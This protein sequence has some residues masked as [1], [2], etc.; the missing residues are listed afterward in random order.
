M[1]HNQVLEKHF[2]IEVTWLQKFLF[3]NPTAQDEIT[4]TKLAFHDPGY[5]IKSKVPEPPPPDGRY[6]SKV[7]SLYFTLQWTWSSKSL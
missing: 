1:L 5:D 7:Y 6:F 4:V 2:S 3:P